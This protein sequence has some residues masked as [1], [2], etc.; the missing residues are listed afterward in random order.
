[1]HAHFLNEFFRLTLNL[2]NHNEHKIRNPSRNGSV[3]SLQLPLFK[4]LSESFHRKNGR[5]REWITTTETTEVALKGLP[6]Y[7]NLKRVI[8]LLNP[9]PIFTK[10]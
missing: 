2:N 9:G 10:R 6:A 7:F 5:L 3:L 1:M 8:Q 4:L